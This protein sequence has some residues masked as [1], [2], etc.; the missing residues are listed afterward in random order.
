VSR[1][2]HIGARVGDRYTLSQPLSRA[3]ARFE[4]W[5]AWDDGRQTGVMALR[6]SP[7]DATRLAVA[8]DVAARILHPHVATLLAAADG[9][10]VYDIDGEP[11]VAALARR[12][13][14][15]EEAL[16]VVD[17]VLS[18]LEHL[19]GQGITC[20][21]LGPHCVILAHRVHGPI[22]AQLVGLGLASVE[23][24]VT[25]DLLAVARLA[26][27]LVAVTPEGLAAAR[28]EGPPPITM[29]L[30]WAATGAPS[31]F[32]AAAAMR[33]ALGLAPGDER[34]A[35]TG[36]A[37]RVV[38]APSMRRAMHGVA[39]FQTSE[40]A[41]LPADARLGGGGARE[42]APSTLPEAP[43]LTARTPGPPPGPA[44]APAPPL[45][46]SSA[47]AGGRPTDPSP[48]PAPP[49]RGG[50][51][52]TTPAPSPPL[53]AAAPP[54]TRPPRPA[55][56]SLVR[57]ARSSDRGTRLAIALIIVLAIAALVAVAVT[58]LQRPVTVGAAA[59]PPR[60]RVTLVVPAPPCPSP[61]PLECA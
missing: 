29:L 54:V 57:P 7:E 10:L 2:P 52:P 26:S 19:H 6:L 30:E 25:D 59:S 9:A 1:S 3:G 35:R 32:A 40:S 17:Q 23:S 15:G 21:D 37:V 20:G 11:L 22:H 36:R 55:L 13:L 50:G 18:A 45:P 16:G 34:R 46:A 14:T 48:P 47:R 24:L 56:A 58:L 61:P 12:R 43:G 31:P 28:E 53:A 60:D 27:T 49:A 33:L 8:R 44:W 41:A 39:D 4:L 38:T 42:G 5:R 51:P